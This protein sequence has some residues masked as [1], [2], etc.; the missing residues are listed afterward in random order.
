VGTVLI[1]QD[2]TVEVEA[3]PGE[4][5]VPC[6]SE[7]SGLSVQLIAPFLSLVREEQTVFIWRDGP[8]RRRGKE[9]RH[10]WSWEDESHR[11]SEEAE[12]ML[13]SPR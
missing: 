3:R 1:G 2:T 7:V 13:P 9:G 6:V 10:W 8:P 4:P 11:L 12:G 5:E